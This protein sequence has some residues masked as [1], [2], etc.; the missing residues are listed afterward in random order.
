MKRSK[1]IFILVLIGVLSGLI[2]LF[3]VDFVDAVQAFKTIF[4]GKETLYNSIMQ[5]I[6]ALCWTV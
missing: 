2:V 3:T 1:L 5:T 4:K 6:N